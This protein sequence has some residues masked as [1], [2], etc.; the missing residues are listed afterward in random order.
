MSLVD[1]V[2]FMQLLKELVVLCL[3]LKHNDALLVLGLPTLKSAYLLILKHGLFVH[4]LNAVLHLL[5]LLH[6]KLGIVGGLG[7]AIVVD[8]LL[9]LAHLDLQLLVLNR[10][11]LDLNVFLLDL[12]HTFFLVLFGFPQLI[13]LLLEHVGEKLNLL[14]LVGNHLSR[15]LW[16]HV[17]G[18]LLLVAVSRW[19][20]AMDLLLLFKH[21]QVLLLQG[22]VLF[23]ELSNFELKILDLLD[24][25]FVDLV[26]GL[27]LGG[28]L[29][30][31]M[32]LTLIHL[33]DASEEAFIL[34]EDGGT[35]VRIHHEV[36]ILLLGVHG[37]VP[38]FVLRQ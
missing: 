11:L 8:K 26:E 33:D 28:L 17:H 7:I 20:G 3:L 12:V 4:L 19:V 14:V 6:E 29:V 32:S 35:E 18:A 30:C 9:Q 1:S 15:L 36:D 13:A 5:A 22:I 2:F 24:L 16:S 21:D 34:L 31:K 37:L 10:G 23:L 25:L 38:V 27:V